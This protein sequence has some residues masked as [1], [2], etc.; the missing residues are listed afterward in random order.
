MQVYVSEDIPVAPKE[1][2]V[3]YTLGQEIE[4]KITFKPRNGKAEQNQ[5]KKIT[6]QIQS[7]G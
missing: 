3:E 4:Q 2:S 6:K 1:V 7:K 5:N